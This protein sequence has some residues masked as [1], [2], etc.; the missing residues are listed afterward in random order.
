MAP[1]SKM[2]GIPGAML[3]FAELADQL[4]CTE[5]PAEVT[6]RGNGQCGSGVN[7]HDEVIDADNKTT[8]LLYEFITR[9]KETV[10][11]LS[12]FAHYAGTTYDFTDQANKAAFDAFTKAEFD[13]MTGEGLPDVL[14]ALSSP[15]SK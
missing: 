1:P 15:E 8:A 7:G 12:T 3:R 13:K 10:A 5:L 2:D 9:F 14:P 4:A 11:A 6:G